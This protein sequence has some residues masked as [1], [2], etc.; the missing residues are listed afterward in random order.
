MFDGAAQAVGLLSN[1]TGQRA[2]LLLTDG[3]DTA[4]NCAPSVCIETVVTAAKQAN[5][6]IYAIGLGLEAGGGEGDLVA[7]AKGSNAGG[8]GVG[9]YLA[10]G[11]AQ[12][13]SLYEKVAT[14]LKKTYVVGWYTTGKPGQ[15][16]SAEITVKYKAAAGDL[17]DSFKLAFVVQ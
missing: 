10:P 1:S 9:Y 8:K 6:P 3:D 4:S 2:V 13:K 14:I 15:N 12:L 16:V 7:L 5:T 11:P 17:S